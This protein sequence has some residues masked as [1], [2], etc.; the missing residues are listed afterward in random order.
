MIL[1]VVDLQHLSKIK[2]EIK[3]KV[4]FSAKTKTYESG[5]VQAINMGLCGNSVELSLQYFKLTEAEKDA[6]VAVFKSKTSTTVCRFNDRIFGNKIFKL[7]TTW[8][9][10]KQQSIEANV[11]T[12]TYDISFILTSF[13]SY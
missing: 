11:A 12:F 4:K 1:T 9:V 13:Y 5:Y 6:I 3:K 2:E 8:T 7:P 10:D